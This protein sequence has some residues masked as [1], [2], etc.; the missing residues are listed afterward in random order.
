MH[1]VSTI[2]IVVGALLVMVG[3]ASFIGC[4]CDKSAKPSVSDAPENGA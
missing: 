1:M 3:L 4:R 2:L